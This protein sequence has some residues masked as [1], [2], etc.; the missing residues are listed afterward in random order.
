MN[1]NVF[2]Y[3]HNEVVSHLEDIII[4]MMREDDV[5]KITIYKNINDRTPPHGVV[6]PSY[7]YIKTK[8]ICKITL[9]DVTKNK[10]HILIDKAPT[11]IL[12]IQTLNKIEEISIDTIYSIESSYK[13]K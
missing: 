3:E 7:I 1:I 5:Y 9:S 10:D 11:S 4:R 13:I 6:Y 2:K 12:T 8:D